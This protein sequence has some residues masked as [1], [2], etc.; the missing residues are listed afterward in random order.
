MARV[1][2]YIEA[3]VVYLILQNQGLS[4]LLCAKEPW[5]DTF[6]LK[7]KL[8]AFKTFPRFISAVLS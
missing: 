3:Q 4:K 1:P 5:V 2:T 7:K 8:I 6:F